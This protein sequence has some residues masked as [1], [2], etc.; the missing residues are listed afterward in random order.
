[1]SA[2]HAQP[3]VSDGGTTPRRMLPFVAAQPLVDHHCHGLLRS[4]G[5]LAGL[6]NEADGAATSA[7]T[8]FDS[9]AGLALRRWCPPLLGLPPH[10]SP[11][12]YL[13]RRAALGWDEVSRRFL[14]ASGLAA[15][16]V[17]TGYTPA[18]CSPPARQRAAP[19]RRRSKSSGLS[20]SL[21]R[22]GGREYP[23]RT[24]PTPTGGR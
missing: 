5:D 16:C 8:P 23:R 19:G 20:K 1:M 15:L 12:S 13:D 17:D 18:T 21:S 14:G 9:L 2:E 6:L 10:A 24:F 7:G 11:E 3:S 4:S 22:W